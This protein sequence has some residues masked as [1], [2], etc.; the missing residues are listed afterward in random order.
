MKE[1]GKKR[2]PQI[3]IWVRLSV[4]I[5]TKLHVSR[6]GHHKVCQGTTTEE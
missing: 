5:N 6:N 4:W 1:L 2:S 3:G